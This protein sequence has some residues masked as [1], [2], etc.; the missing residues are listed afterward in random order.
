VSEIVDFNY[1]RPREPRRASTATTYRSPGGESH[2]PI[3]FESMALLADELATT[4]GDLL[5]VLV[6][7]SCTGKD[8]GS[9]VLRPLW[10]EESMHRAYSFMRLVDIRNSRH[11]A[12]HKKRIAAKLEGAIARNLVMRFSELETGGERELLPCSFLLRNIASGFVALFGEPAN[13]SIESAVENVALPAYQRRALV[14]AAA[15][16]VTNALLHAFQG[17][18][19]GRIEVGLSARGPS[20]LCLRVAD[21]GIGFTDR[22]PN[23]QCGVA[24][25]LA[26]LL[27]A[28]LAYHRMMD[29]TI[30]EIEFPA[31]NSQPGSVPG[32]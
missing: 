11:V 8:Y 21:N 7:S 12:C 3:R 5:G 13:I 31:A 29:W 26:E 2:F 24:A 1:Q 19:S 30:A 22:S 6:A 25:G 32:F 10:A 17:R 16:L 28:Q 14:L 23:L 15:E 27:E 9:E 4:Y 20:S 18:E